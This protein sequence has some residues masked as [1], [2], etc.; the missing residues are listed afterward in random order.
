MAWHHLQYVDGLVRLGHDVRFVEDS[1]DYPSCYDPQRHIT[2]SDPT[3]GLR[4]AADAFGRLGLANSWSYYDAHSAQWFGPGSDAEDFCRSADVVLNISGVNPLRDWTARAPVRVFVDTDPL[5]TQIRHLHD[6]TALARGRQHNAFVSFGE[7]IGLSSCS[8]PDDGFSWSPTRQPIVLSRWKVKQAPPGA[9]FTTVMQWH[10]Y[11]SLEHEGNTYGTKAES[12]TPFTGLP[13]STNVPLEIALGG[14]GAPGE[15][16]ASHGWKIR[17]P[18]E[19]AL[20]PWDY[21]D[22]IAGSKGE[23]TVAKDGYVTSNCG[24]F[25][26]R[27]AAYLASGRPVLTQET[28]F[29]GWLPTGKGVFSFR[30]RDELLSQ[31]EEVVN[32]YDAHAK[33]ARAVAEDFFDSDVVL[34]TLIDRVTDSA[35]ILP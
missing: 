1:D 10:S 20:S 8:V 33:S 29:S 32:D 35:G 30:S 2:D 16:L 13:H 31:L 18:L 4:F 12:F 5:F 19:V 9:P 23:V 21:Q 14:K 24:W 11:A 26:E 27:S 7:N 15:E 3:Y 28:G 17:N 25:S 34:K 22:Y 6:S